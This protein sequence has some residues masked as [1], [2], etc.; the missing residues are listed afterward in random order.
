MHILG[1]AWEALTIQSGLSESGAHSTLLLERG[2]QTEVWVLFGVR[3]L[4]G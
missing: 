4:F 3:V 1:T 2:G